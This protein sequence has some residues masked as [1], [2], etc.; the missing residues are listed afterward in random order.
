MRLI[1]LLLLSLILSACQ[2]DSFYVENASLSELQDHRAAQPLVVRGT[3]PAA[4]KEYFGLSGHRIVPG[5]GTVLA[6][7][8]FSGGLIPLVD[9]GGFEKLTVVLPANFSK[10]V[11]ENISLSEGGKV[12]VFWS[13][14]SSNFP[15]ESGCY[16]YASSG[17]IIVATIARDTITADLDMILRSISPGGWE[18]ECGTLAF[19]KTL[20]LDRKTVQQLTPWEGTSGSHI[21]DESIRK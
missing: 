10:N 7:R 9:Q 21:Y 14:G 17:S 8:A 1:T 15:G 6:Y 13:R 4:L 16:G 3:R 2:T 5:I 12:I 19:K 11:G 20:T 18:K